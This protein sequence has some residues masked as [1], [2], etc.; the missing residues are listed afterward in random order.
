MKNNKITMIT[1]DK[2]STIWLDGI[3]YAGGTVERTIANLKH[4]LK[5]GCQFSDDF[6]IRY[7]LRHSP[8]PK[9]TEKACLKRASTILA[10]IGLKHTEPQDYYN[11]GYLNE[12]RRVV[13]I[14]K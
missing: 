13:T 3:P 12:G 9:R 5:L 6:F 8:S 1:F 14:V 4:C 10:G 7:D 2:Q 11:Q